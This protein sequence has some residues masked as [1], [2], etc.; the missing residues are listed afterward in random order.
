MLIS[1]STSLC[2]TSF[3]EVSVYSI[4]PG[5]LYVSDPKV[6]EQTFKDM[7]SGKLNPYQYARSP[8]T[9]HG[10]GGRY[11][12]SWYIPVK[13]VIPEKIIVPMKQVT[14]NTVV[15]E[16]AKEKLKTDKKEGIPHVDPKNIKGVRS[17]KMTSRRKTTKRAA[18][19]IDTL[20][21]KVKK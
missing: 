11:T 3:Q 4:M 2:G 6:W 15:E 16:R 8:Q 20:S 17:S 5:K 21:K 18:S 10:L 9:G 7:V 14:P 1:Q 13:P 19:P 12:S